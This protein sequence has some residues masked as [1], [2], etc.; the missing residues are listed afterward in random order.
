VNES[1]DRNIAGFNGAMDFKASQDKKMT[2]LNQSH[3]FLLAANLR[4][5]ILPLHNPTNFGGTLL[6]PTDKVGCLVGIGS[7][8]IPVIVEHQAALL[9]LQVV[10]PSITD[11]DACTTIDELNALPT[12]PEIGGIVNL[13]GLQTFFPAPFLRNAI[14]AE[15]TSSPLILALTGRNA[16]E[17]HIRLHSGEEGFDEGDV[18][19][20]IKLFTLWCMGVHQGQ[21]NETRFSVEPDDGEL[22]SHYTR[23][24]LE[25]I[26]SSLASAS[27]ASTSTA[28]TYDILKTLAAGITHTHEEAENQNKIQREQLDYIKEKDAKKKN[29]VEKW[30][31][32]CR[33][34]VLNAASTDSDS[35][36]DDIPA[37]YL[38]I[39]NSDT[40]GMADRELHNQMSEVNFP[41]V[42]FAHGLAAS[43]YV[44]DLMWNNKNSPSN[45]SP[46][47]VYEQDPLSSSQTARC[48]HL[49]LLSKNTEGK[50]LEEIKASQKQEIKVPATFE[51]MMQSLRFYGGVTTIL[52]G[53]SCVEC[54]E[55]HLLHPTR[56]GHLQNANRRRR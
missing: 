56:K 36:A 14:L 33:R 22:E 26:M 52:F 43:I 17:E 54:K 30:H 24:H 55:R 50:S 47:T 46:F 13:E 18:N 48:L 49:H 27:A 16:G 25:N 11:I 6:R 34:L 38:Q 29:K 3:G 39:I 51:E 5:E 40:A 41:D 1:G 2:T 45:V 21:V 9:S 10:V 35:P 7:K 23:L 28:D 19:D 53:C 42:G 20:H 32:T 8:A 12:P 44:G 15:D 37:S 4:K 31:S